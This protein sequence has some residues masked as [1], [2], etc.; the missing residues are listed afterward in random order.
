MAKRKSTVKNS[1]VVPSPEQVKNAQAEPQNAAH[2]MVQN[3]L[4]EALLGVFPGF[5]GNQVSQVDTLFKNLRNYFISNMRQPLSQ[6]YVE[7]GII[8]TVVNVPV[9]DAF[10]GGYELKSSMLDG[11]NLEALEAEIESIGLNNN[12]LGQASKWNRL[13]GGAG[14]IIMTDQDPMTPLDW[15]AIGEKSDLEFRSADMWELY[16]NH[17]Q[18]EGVSIDGR[19]MEPEFY[20][21]YGVKLHKSRVMLMKGLEAPS[22]VRPRLRGWGFSIVLSH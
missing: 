3:G 20:D 22:F 15:D 13:F 14:I 18:S 17:Q 16:Y 2:Q 7:H 21:Y 9:D 8:Q 19:L 6:M 4:T 10:R 5:T 12:V 11:K 1:I